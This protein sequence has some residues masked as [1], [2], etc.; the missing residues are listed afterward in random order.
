MLTTFEQ[1]LDS[2]LG[3]TRQAAALSGGFGFLALI[4]AAIGVYG[5]T[6][7]A[8]STRTRDI[9]IRLA[10]GATPSHVGGT[11]ARRGLSLLLAGV[12]LGV[13]SAYSLARIFAP[14]LFG[15]GSNDTVTFVGAA[16]L[17]ALVSC[18]AIYI[19]VRRAMR[20]DPLVA[21]RHE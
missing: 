21:I 11:I 15:V 18:G 1:Q 4:L 5:V 13:A 7:F 8:V 17:L 9:G 16:L 2:S 3:Q 19:P 14:L 20:L 10:L 12:M 6:A